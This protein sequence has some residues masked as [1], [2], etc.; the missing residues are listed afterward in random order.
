MRLVEHVYE[1][2]ARFPETERYGLTAQIRRAAISVPSNVA[3][4]QGVAGVKWSLRHIRI[5]IGSLAEVET[6]LEAALRL[7]FTAPASC[8][9]LFACIEDARR[10]LYGM[11][12]ER[13]RRLHGGHRHPLPTSAS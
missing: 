9:K 6:Q 13:L 11:R 4:G 2:S 8:E 12:R 10:L 7:K 5:A 1:I 3:E